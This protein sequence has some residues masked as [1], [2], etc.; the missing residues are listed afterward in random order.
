MI[1]NVKVI[2]SSKDTVL[3]LHNDLPIWLEDED[4]D[5]LYHTTPYP[6]FTLDT[7]IGGG[8]LDEHDLIDYIIYNKPP[9]PIKIDDFKKEFGSSPWTELF[10]VDSS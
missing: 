10:S 8:K 3:S 1:I 5:E 2:R 6:I 4:E 9:T 7:I